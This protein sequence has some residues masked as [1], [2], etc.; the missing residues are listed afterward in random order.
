MIEHVCLARA[1]IVQLE[2]RAGADDPRHQARCWFL[3]EL[4]YSV[5]NVSRVDLTSRPMHVIE[6]VR[7]ALRREA[8]SG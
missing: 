3:Q 2:P 8:D 5:L 4:G 1:L 6:D 7:L